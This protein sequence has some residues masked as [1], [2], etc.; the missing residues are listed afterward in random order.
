MIQKHRVR[1]TV[2]FLYSAVIFRAYCFQEVVKM[3][4][5]I[6]RQVIVVHAPDPNLFEQAIFILKDSAVGSEGITDAALLKEANRLIHAGASRKKGVR[7]L[8]GAVWACAGAA[9]TGIAWLLCSLL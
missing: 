6:S 3:V 9:V 5:G 8:R 4:K 1:N 7:Q 2:L